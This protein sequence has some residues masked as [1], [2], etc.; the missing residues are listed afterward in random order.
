M[1]EGLT[2]TSVMTVTVARQMGSLG[3]FAATE[4]AGRLGYRYLD[5]EYDDDGYLYDV[6]QDGP[7]LGL[8]W[9]F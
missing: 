4:V 6:T 3:S 8:V 9:R 2:Y 5:I 1:V 7:M